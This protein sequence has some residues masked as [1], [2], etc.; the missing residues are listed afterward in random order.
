MPNANITDE[1]LERHRRIRAGFI[2][3]GTSLS[4]WCAGRG[5]KHQNARK[6]IHGEWTGPKAAAL[7]TELMRASGAKE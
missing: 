7:V 1:A 3:N 2:A 5:L 6:A 4:A